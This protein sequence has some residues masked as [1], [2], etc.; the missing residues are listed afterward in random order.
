MVV[1]ISGC[2]SDTVDEQ[3]YNESEE[4]TEFQ[5][6]ELTPIAK[7]RN[8]AIKGTQYIDRETYELEVYGLVGNELDISYEQ[9]LEYP[10]VTRF[11]RMDCVEGWGFDA[12]WTGITLNT[13]FDE[14]QVHEGANEVIFHSADGYSTSLDIN[15]LRDNDIMLAY[16]L[17][18]ITLPPDRGFPLQLVAEDKYG[19]K[20]AK[21]IIGIEIIDYPYEGYWER[22]GYNNNADVGGPRFE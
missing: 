5:G 10:N 14:A 21:W 8:N 2:I 17:N 20:W 22:V 7:Q 19:Y 1:I 15:Y 6:I 18:D 13:I 3:S 4:A 9:L 16:E 11:V 12:K